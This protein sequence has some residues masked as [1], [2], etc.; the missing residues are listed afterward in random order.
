MQN[1]KIIMISIWASALSAGCS[2]IPELDPLQRVPPD[3]VVTHIQCELAR[4]AYKSKFRDWYVKY[5]LTL[6][7]DENAGLSPS[8][9]ITSP[10]QGH[11]FGLGAGV[12]VSGAA[13]RI[14]TLS[15]SAKLSSID[16]TDCADHTT[17]YQDLRG[18]L[19]ID[20]WFGELEAVAS[21]DRTKIGDTALRVKR[22][23]TKGDPKLAKVTDVAELE[24]FGH[25]VQFIIV[26]GANIAPTLT[27]AKVKGPTPSGNF[28]AISRTDTHKLVLAFSPIDPASGS[29]DRQLT[30]QHLQLLLGPG[31]QFNPN[32][33]H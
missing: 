31:N 26:G 13:T 14:E 1:I 27:I 5:D 33:F 16:K 24:S 2:Y 4:A 25:T 8:V 11:S 19:G 28:A 7:V 15:V 30:T 12:N 17:S 10:F 22:R 6:Q 21:T 20:E 3:K 9:V 29:T 18:D 23:S 32:L